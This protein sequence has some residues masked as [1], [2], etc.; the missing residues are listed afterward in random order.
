MMDF[1]DLLNHLSTY[2]LLLMQD[3]RLPSV[4]GVIAG[5]PLSASW[6]GHP[7]GRQIFRCLEHLHAHPDVVT[8]RLIGGKVTYLHRDL[9][10]AL[11]AVVTA[12]E[13]W[14]RRGLSPAARALL[15]RVGAGASV[16]AAGPDA[17]ELQERLLAYAQEVHTEA[18]QHEVVLRPWSAVRDRLGPLPLP[19]A[20]EGRA[21]LEQAAVAVGARE[22]SL[23]W[24][25]LAKGCA[26]GA[27]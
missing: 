23:P 27:S 12:G 4:V 3:K 9:W 13:A 16:R 22:S 20:E 8:T 2:G 1:D 26:E 11:L 5:G 14:Q 17:K 19:T 21:Q 18:G 6:W 15:R 7:R 10:P 24:H 25:R